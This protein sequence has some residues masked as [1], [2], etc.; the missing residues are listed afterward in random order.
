MKS[1]RDVEE[2][3]CELDVIN[4][5]MKDNHVSEADPAPV[6]N[7]RVQQYIEEQQSIN[8]R[9][10]ANQS[11]PFSVPNV[12]GDRDVPVAPPALNQTSLESTLNTNTPVFVPSSS[13]HQPILCNSSILL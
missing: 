11:E 7:E 9:R 12:H 1:K 2:A 5:C 10:V 13:E 6:K 3:Q 8:S 4:E